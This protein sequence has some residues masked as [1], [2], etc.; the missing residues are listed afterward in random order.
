MY[1]NV[2]S[3][4]LIVP[5]VSNPTVESTLRIVPNAGVLFVRK[6]LPACS[7][8]PTVVPLDKATLK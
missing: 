5:L 8:L 4:K 2:L 7:N 6:V 3:S 1:V